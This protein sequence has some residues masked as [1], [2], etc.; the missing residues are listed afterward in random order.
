MWQ[1]GRGRGKDA[2]IE[3]DVDGVPD[4]SMWQP[5]RGRGKDASIE[6]D[7]DGVP[8][9]SMWQPGRSSRHILKEDWSGKKQ[10]YR[11]T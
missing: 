6:R 4:R 11:F 7:V 2:S 8:D 3:R 1:P 5:G 10:Q 9:R